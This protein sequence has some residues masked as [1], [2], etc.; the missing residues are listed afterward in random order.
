MCRALLYL[1]RVD[2]ARPL[3]AKLQARGWQEDELLGLCRKYGL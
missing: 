1:G 3:V 2:E